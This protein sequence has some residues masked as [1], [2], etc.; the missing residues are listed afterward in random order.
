MNTGKRIRLS[1]LI[2]RTSGRSIIVPMDHGASMG[3]LDGLTNLRNSAVRLQL[4]PGLVQGVVLQRGAMHHLD[5]IFLSSSS[6]ARVLHLSGGT[7]LDPNP[8][9]KSLVAQVEDALQTGADAV[10]VQVN[11]GA[12]GESTMLRDMGT[13]ASACERWNMPLLAMMYVR[14]DGIASTQVAD[15]MFAARVAAETGA[16]MV[17]VSCPATGERMREVVDGSFIPVLVAGGEFAHDPSRTAQ[18]VRNAIVGGAAGICVGRN[19]FQAQ[20]P[21]ETLQMLAS[22]VHG[23]VDRPETS[24]GD[25]KHRVALAVS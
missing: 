14:R 24:S 20:H 6:P 5:T 3:P 12:P 1:R 17:K 16:D 4:A 15:V 22:I 2:H 9:T 8:G 25:G 7:S 11:L 13:V 23:S 10:S 19:V 18:I 21:A